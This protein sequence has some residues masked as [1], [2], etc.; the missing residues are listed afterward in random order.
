MKSEKARDWC[1]LH[2]LKLWLGFAGQ[3]QRWNECRVPVEVEGG[4]N[5]GK[6]ETVQGPSRRLRFE[7]AGNRV[8]VRF[9][10][11]D[12]KVVALRFSGLRVQPEG[13]GLRYE[14]LSLITWRLPQRTGN[15][16]LSRRAMPSHHTAQSIRG[17]TI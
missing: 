10:V 16:R 2:R 6:G 11:S 12:F 5:K 7:D 8:Q 17:D 13:S 15:R 9:Q 1:S 3:D 4:R 14:G